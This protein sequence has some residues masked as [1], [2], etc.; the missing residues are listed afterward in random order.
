MT[1][2]P[3]MRLRICRT[4]PRWSGAQVNRGM[5][6]CAARSKRC[7]SAGTLETT[8]MFSRSGALRSAVASQNCLR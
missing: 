6:L 4:A 7:E 1:S 3:R 8:F 2:D 5:S